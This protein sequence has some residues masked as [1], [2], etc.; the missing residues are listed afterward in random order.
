MTGVGKSTLINA[1][2]G[3]DL[4]P[5]E[6]GRLTTGTIVRL[7]H[8]PI[9][10]EQPRANRAIVEYHSRES[11]LDLV[12]DLCQE[13]KFPLVLSE[14]WLDL[15]RTLEEIRKQFGFKCT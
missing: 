13:G 10:P 14:R 12:T 5:N 6:E 7:K 4:F 1:L 11:F 8:F 15:R 9:Q 3:R 2:H